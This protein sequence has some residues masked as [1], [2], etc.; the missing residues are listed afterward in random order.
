MSNNGWLQV[1]L[2]EV[3]IHRK[4][5]VQIND[6]L[7][8]KRCRVQLR[9]QGVVLRDEV[10]GTQIKTKTQQVCRANE[11]LVAE[12]DAKMGGLGLVPPEL[13]GAIVSS[14]YF[15]FT[16][17]TD[18]LDPFFL[19]YFCRTPAFLE[20]VTSR[21]TTNYAAI[22]PGHVLG[23]K[24]P[25]PPLEEQRR[26]VGRIDRLIR[27]IEEANHLRHRL[28]SANEALTASLHHRLS[29]D[30][31]VRMGC[32]VELGEERIAVE[33]TTS[34]PQVGIRGFGGGLFAKP[35]VTGAETTYR[36]FNRLQAGM[37]VLS[38][39]KGWEG[40]IAVCKSDLVGYFASPEYRTFRCIN[41]ECDPDYLDMVVR[42]PW[43]R[44]LLQEATHGQGARRE[45]T[46]PERFIEIVL[47]MPEIGDQRRAVKILSKLNSLE[48][49]ERKASEIQDAMLP[50]ILDRAFKGG[51]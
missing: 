51:L 6:L 16:P 42:S 18:R 31:R 44:T 40:A 35:P 1:P 24:I 21:G 25:L 38:Q 33:A 36:H 49:L 29:R 41:S 28:K 23:Y 4:E 5:F 43:F 3:V 8:Y 30:R 7:R 48:P 50:S 32:L 34:Y 47:P 2:G 10:D 14:H 19:G 12:I 46:R 9:A 37:L 17:K 45:R 15:L 22:R 39:V 26:I 11:F 20:Q 27:R 13:D